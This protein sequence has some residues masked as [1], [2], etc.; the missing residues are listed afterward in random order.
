MIKNRLQF[1]RKF[2]LPEDEAVIL[3]FPSEVP[4]Y[5]YSPHPIFR[6]MLAKKLI[7]IVNQRNYG[8]D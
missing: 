1:F 3:P 8:D 5:M 7:S 6:K 2:R 4:L